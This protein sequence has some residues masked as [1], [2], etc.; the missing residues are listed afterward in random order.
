MPH[1]VVVVAASL[2]LLLLLLLLLLGW[3]VTGCAG[4][5]GPA[6]TDQWMEGDRGRNPVGLLGG[7]QC[8]AVTGGK[9]HKAA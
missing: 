8:T 7:E 5:R 9:H 6:S 1:A 2:I 4:V 3:G